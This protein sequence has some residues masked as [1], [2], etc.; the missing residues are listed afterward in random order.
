M[1]EGAPAVLAGLPWQAV[2]GASGTVGAVSD[3]ARAEQWTDGAITLQVLDQLHDRLLDAGHVDRV[4]LAGLKDDRRA[5]IGGGLSILRAL[6]NVLRLDRI[7]PARGA[8]RHGVLYEMINREAPQQDVRAATVARLQQKFGVD[9]VQ[10]RRVADMALWLFAA[11]HPQATPEARGQPK[12]EL[13]RRTARVRHGGVA[14]RASTGTASTSF[15]T[16]MRPASPSISCSVWPR[17][18][19][20]SAAGCARWSRRC[21]DPVLRDQTL[22]LRIALLLCHARSDPEPGRLQL[23]HT[24]DGYRLVIEPAWA[25]LHPQS[26]FLLREEQKAWSRMSWVFEV[27]V[28]GLRP[29]RLHRL[30]RLHAHQKRLGACLGVWLRGCATT[31]PRPCESSRVLRCR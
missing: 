22:V 5:V 31:R 12:A 19:W 6:C 7:E 2:Y 1:L 4:A 14:R 23:Q 8:L 28:D 25:E 30:R 17:W 27:R 15:G 20:R 13:G 9:T 11:L 29:G 16:P 3:M 21:R 10:A 26:I 18:C 24:G